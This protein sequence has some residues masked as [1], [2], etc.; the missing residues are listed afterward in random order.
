MRTASLNPD[1]MWRAFITRDPR[2]DGAFVT[3]VRST[4]IFCR[5][6]CTCRKPRRDRVTYFRTPAA[7]MKAGFRACMRC[8][9]ELRGGSAEADRMLVERALRVMK[10]RFGEPI[11]LATL[12]SEVALSVS[13]FSRR[14]RATDGRT[15]MRALADLR[16]ERA[17]ALLRDA[18]RTALEAGL[19]AGF[20]SASA[21]KRAFKRRFGVNPAMIRRSGSR[22]AKLQRGGRT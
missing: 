15:P 20:Q 8:R 19:D 17:R 2:Y 13:R 10:E 1:T 3:G 6:T 21:F 5:P 12:A 7:A 14:F 22:T 4:G 16:A 9:P 18:S 11:A